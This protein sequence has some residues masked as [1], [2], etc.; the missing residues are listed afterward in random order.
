MKFMEEIMNNDLFRIDVKYF[1]IVNKD[2]YFQQELISSS[3][4]IEAPSRL[5]CLEHRTSYFND[6]SIFIIL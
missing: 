2:I 1:K 6:D 3:S 4:D 5:K